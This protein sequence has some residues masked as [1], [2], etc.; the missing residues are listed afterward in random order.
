M[1]R[2]S[3]P[4]VCAALVMICFLAV[5]VSLWAMTDAGRDAVDASR[6]SAAA[7]D[8]CVIQ[9]R[10]VQLQKSPDVAIKALG[11]ECIR[12]GV[13][14]QVGADFSFLIA[15]SALTLALFLF[16]RALRGGGPGLLVLGVL[17]VFAMA[18]GD[19]FENKWTLELIRL[20]REGLSTKASLKLLQYGGWIKWGALGL[21]AAVLGALW[22]L[23]RRLAW[24][25]KI[26][27]LASAAV[28]LAGLALPGWET[29]AAS[30]VV[31][32]LFWIVALI[33]AIAVTVDRE[34]YS[35][36][37]PFQERGAKS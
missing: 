4:K 7:S 21:S 8:E 28:V 16:V 11:S 34:A 26:L 37:R 3:S 33:H 32:G 22:P 29:L 9:N 1:K 35:G 23:S 2:L 30:L 13:E 20:L 5:L 25:P 14:A 10:V 18:A 36:S 19:A 31:L 27:A 6:K 17:L 12:S 24:A 15:Y